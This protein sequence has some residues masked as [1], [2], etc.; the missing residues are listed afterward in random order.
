MDKIP[1]KIKIIE[2]KD[3]YTDVFTPLNR[4]KKYYY[5]SSELII[6]VY[7]YRIIGISDKK[8]YNNKLYEIDKKLNN[9]DKK[10]LKITTGFDSTHSKYLEK[11]FNEVWDKVSFYNRKKA[12]FVMSLLKFADVF[13][14]LPNTA[15]SNLL[16]LAFEKMLELLI[17]NNDEKELK[18]LERTVF[19]NICYCHKYIYK[20]FKALEY[21][22]INNKVLYYGDIPDEEIYFL[23]F[24]ANMGC[25]IL[26]FNTFSD[27]GFEEIDSDSKYSIKLDLGKV[28]RL[29]PFPN[30]KVNYSNTTVA[31][32]ASQ[33]VNDILFTEEGGFYKPWQFIDYNL[34]KVPLKTTYDE[35]YILGKQKSIFRPDFKINDFTVFIP[36]LFTKI[37]GIH[38]D[39]NKYFEEITLLKN[40]ENAIF[41]NNS[42]LI[43]PFRQILAGEIWGTTPIYKTILD[44]RLK[45]SS[46]KLLNSKLW[47]YSYL[48]PGLQKMIAV[49]IS[50]ICF[51][52]K[53]F[54]EKQCN[55]DTRM[56]IFISLLKMK[57]EYL[58]LLQKFDYTGHVPKVIIYNKDIVL[59]YEEVIFLVFLNSLAVDIII[60]SPS[61]YS[62]IENFLEPGF[63]DIHNLEDIKI[64]L[65]FKEYQYTS[66]IKKIFKYLK[67]K[68]NN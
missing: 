29:K 49:K 33:E 66:P 7:F 12:N 22:H 54:K 2:A 6:P 50:D 4:R 48:K 65:D 43:K 28:A 9:L 17:Y 13:P 14:K 11:K 31:Y 8:E 60:Y 20:L 1:F 18:D 26:F 46:E 42:R 25:D 58:N 15:V 56:K 38:T 37:S 64:E 44:K 32:E 24:L 53:R 3:I 16:F 63:Y 23:I 41:I 19:A 51:T 39:I 27:C 59:S 57:T 55:T 61:A 52:L 34:E 36:S 40:Q 21:K 68:N 67:T 62:D 45:I 10:Y 35:I 5:N 30:S 47:N